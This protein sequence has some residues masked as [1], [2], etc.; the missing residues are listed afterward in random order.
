ME[1]AFSICLGLALAACCGFRVFVPLLVTNV[2]YLTGYLSPNTGFEWMAGWPAFAVLA[3][4]TALEIAAYYIPVVDNVLD[5]VAT[6]AAFIAGTVLMTSLVDGGDPIL[7]WALGLI[8]GG[9]SAG[10]IQAG[11]GLLRL[12]STATTGGLG[13]PVV[14]TTENVFAGFF[15]VLGLFLPVLV[16]VLA[17]G[18]LVFVGKRLARRFSADPPARVPSAKADDQ[19]GKPLRG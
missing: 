1:F 12:G 2:A 3:T 18:L 5:A 10:L 15:S 7:R 19:T 11:T 4:A 8:V 17:V 13:N 16:A 14:A 9:G 6:P